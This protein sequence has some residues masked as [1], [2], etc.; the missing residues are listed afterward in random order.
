M[1]FIYHNLKI[2]KSQSKLLQY[3]ALYCMN[4]VF[5]IL[6]PVFI[7]VVDNITTMITVSMIIITIFIMI[8][9]ITIVI[10]IIIIVVII[11]VI[12]II[13]IV[14]ITIVIIIIINLITIVIRISLTKFTQ[15]CITVQR[16]VRLKTST[17][18]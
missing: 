15:C 5:V 13:T 1:F 14:I 6:F 12:I 17:L 7:I 4:K 16:Y 10:I 3:L 2:L 8:A 11:I 18:L 9:F